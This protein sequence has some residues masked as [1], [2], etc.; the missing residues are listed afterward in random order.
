MTEQQGAATAYAH[1]LCSPGGRHTATIVLT[2]QV[3]R[4]HRDGPPNAVNPGD[5][6][7]TIITSAASVIK[8]TPYSSGWM[9]SSLVTL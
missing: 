8:R 5:E 6:L 7:H 4:D 2:F 3:P 9:S 1:F